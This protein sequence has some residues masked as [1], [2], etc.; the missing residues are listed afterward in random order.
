MTSNRERKVWLVQSRELS[1]I[2][3]LLPSNIGRQSLVSSLIEAYELDSLC[4]GIV[5]VYAA[6]KSELISYH[7][8]EFINFLLKVRSDVDAGIENL[9]EIKQYIEEEMTKT[10]DSLVELE[11]FGLLHDCYPFP[12]MGDYVKLIA[13]T[14]ISSVKTLIQAKNY[15]THNIVIN[16]YGGRHHCHKAKVAGFCYVNDI[17][18]GIQILRK[19]FSRVFYLDLDLHHGNGV[20]NAYRAS[21]NVLTCSIHR[22]DIG[23]YPGS[24]S[25][26]D[27]SI[28]SVN[29][30]TKRGLSDTSMMYIIK[31]I[32]LPLIERFD[33][34]ALVIQTGCDGLSTDEHNEWNLSIKCMGSVINHLLKET[35]NVPTLILGGGGYNHTETAKCWT[36]ITNQILQNEE[37]SNKPIPEHEH[38]D[39]YEKDGFQF[40]TNDNTIPKRMK[41]ENTTE[42]LQQ[43]RDYILN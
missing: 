29:I 1:I 39:A 34:Q 15:D 4:E 10:D 26:K 24:G 36:F 20:E 32:V 14:T 8:K 28:S 33:P 31:D 16:W 12:F 42:Y 13:G 21:K 17:V 22:Y 41:D 23:F 40:W 9:E 30:P 37:I 25:L 7:D 11:K 5:R 35:K 19:S 2:T 43:M 18:L 3:D 27:S 38:L 6:T